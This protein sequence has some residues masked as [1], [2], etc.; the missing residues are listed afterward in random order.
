MDTS[1]TTG[2]PKAVMLTHRN[3][4]EHLG[5]AARTWGYTEDNAASALTRAV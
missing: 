2:L 4:L 3:L 1:G 5:D